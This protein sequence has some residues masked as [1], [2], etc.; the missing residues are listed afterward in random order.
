MLLFLII[1][2]LVLPILLVWRLYRI[3]IKGDSQIQLMGR[4]AAAGV[5]GGAV[6][7]TLSSFIFGT[8]AY[9]PIGYLYWLLTTAIL[10]MAF[11]FIIG[12][13]QKSGLSPNLLARLVV[14]SLIGIA[15][16]AVW[17]LATGMGFSAPSSWFGKG[18][19]CMIIA[20]GLVSGMLGG[21]LN[22]EV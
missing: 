10:G 9:A 22:K 11:T 6:G 16:S 15:T 3:P 5:A 18:I 14:G 2:F 19:I 1:L 20:S 12:A 8:G 7:A 4:G 13:L 17:A 21:P